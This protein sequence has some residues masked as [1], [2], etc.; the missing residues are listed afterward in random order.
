MRKTVIFN[1]GW[2]FVKTG[3]NLE[4][5]Q[6][7]AGEAVTP[8]HT[9]NAF[10]GQDGG[11]DYYRG[12]C[13][14]IKRF[15]RPVGKRIF[16]QF[17][18]VNSI[19]EVYVNGVFAARHEGGYSIF[20]V[21]ITKY[22]KD[23]NEICISAD[24]SPNQAVYPQFADFTFYGGI[25][26]DVS[27]ICCD[28]SHF[29]LSDDGSCG[30]YVT[31]TVEGKDAS[32][33]V[34][35]Q[36]T[37]VKDGQTICLRILNGERKLVSEKTQPAHKTS[38]E[39][40]IPD[41]H[42]WDG[43][44]DPYLYTAV[45][46]LLE[47]GN[48][49]DRVSVPFGVRS[50]RV[51][52]KEGFFL[53][54]R[55]YP[56]RGVSRHQDRL[57]KGNALS[58]EDHE[59]DIRL[60]LEMGANFIRL[61]HYQHDQYF[62]DLCDRHG[63]VVWAEIPFISRYMPEGDQNTISQMTE[64]VK[65]NYNHPSIVCWG[66]SNEITMGGVDEALINIHHK[67]NDL[68]HSLDPTRLT[69]MANLS[70]L[71]A[72]SPMNHIPDAFSYN[73]YFGWYGGKVE[74]NGP[75][76]DACHAQLPDKAFGLSEYGCEAILKWHTSNPRCGDYTEEY[77]AYYHEKM[78]ETFANRPFLWSTAVWNMFDF[79]SDMRDEGG[80]AGRNNKGL[81]TFDRKTRKDSYFIYKA[82]WSKIPF[83]HICGRRYLERAEEISQVKVY[84]NC[85]RVSLY[86]NNQLVEEKEGRY[87]FTFHVPL[88][89]GENILTVQSG[90]QSDEITLIRVETP[91][92]DYVLPFGDEEIANWFDEKGEKV[93]FE[94]PEGYFSV[95][96]SIDDIMKNPMAAAII[97][98]A[99][100]AMMKN[101]SMGG[102]E[103]PPEFMGMLGSF[104]IER[105]FS[106]AGMAGKKIP[107]E[108][109]LQVNQML[110]KIKK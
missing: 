60:I 30:I 41:V 36:V 13:W 81:V 94:F 3:F 52:P 49:L 61:A 42:L 11:N 64:L 110:N 104:S 27:L 45:A 74:D 55:S 37:G 88:K 77:Q 100:G 92:P 87:V 102:M 19:A 15:P 35:T 75:W 4:E 93:V 65:Q 7:A 91:N 25:Y 18:G 28:D 109:L 39:L 66:L 63:L 103:I 86:V 79:G 40:S 54:G 12:K 43:V 96:D 73:H 56:L 20:R 31:P 2:R 107:K 38:F 26:R 97:T 16:I 85:E 1:E 10:D 51:D 50:F 106:L 14:Y 76:L 5:V 101:F 46:V 82:W 78:L 9:W 90:D 105:L 95:R 70:M 98:D 48:E 59:E 89:M 33:G 6:K 8:P 47:E 72:D 21:D 23:E 80:V 68:C 17:N 24:N 108:A 83:V 84:S 71:P 34:D 58:R 44:D 29:D 67:L 99:L 32:I 53:N 57:N 69:V 22:L 62:Y